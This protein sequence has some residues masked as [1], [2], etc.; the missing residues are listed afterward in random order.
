M[1]SAR[2]GLLQGR[3]CA[4]RCRKGQT[5]PLIMLLPGVVVVAD[6][7]VA[8]LTHESSASALCAMS[9]IDLVE[10][11]SIV[12]ISRVAHGFRA[13]RFSADDLR[14]RGAPSHARREVEQVGKM[15]LRWV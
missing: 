9:P 5:V 8:K 1:I 3:I 15:R 2:I 7:A 6:G 11:C 14:A 12:R 10:V 4:L 13:I